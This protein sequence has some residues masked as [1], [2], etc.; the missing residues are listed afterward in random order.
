LRAIALTIGLAV[1]LG[2][3]GTSTSKTASTAG[4]NLRASTNT[5]PADPAP[6]TAPA[7]VHRT[8]L[9]ANAGSRARSTSGASPSTPASSV[10]SASAGA[11]AHTTTSPSASSGVAAP[12]ARKLKHMHST[13]K[14]QPPS[15]VVPRCTKLAGL[16][17]THRLGSTKWQAVVIGSSDDT[18]FVVGPYPSQEAAISAAGLL[19][20]SDVGYQGGFYVAYSTRASG[21]E[22]DSSLLAACLQA[23]T[24]QH[25]TF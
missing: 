15:V 23:A 22:G 5:V 24:P 4:S 6:V 19:S 14:E 7:A 2:G 17:H 1:A 16:D 9:H 25:Y 13:P 12:T 10:P 8:P 18:V 3:C 21:L 11:P 20:K